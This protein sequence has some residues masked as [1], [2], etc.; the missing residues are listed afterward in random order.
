ML[1]TEKEINSILNFWF[2]ND[3]YNNFWFDK[4]VDE[5]IYKEYYHLLFNTYN[6]IVDRDDL[7][8]SY[9]ENL[10]L[11]ILFDQ[12][13]RNINR[14]VNINVSEMTY[15]ARKLSLI[16][17]KNKYYLNKKM[18]HICFMLMPLRHLNK[19]TDYYLILEILREI[20]EPNNFIFNKFKNQTMKKLDLLKD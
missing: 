6:T 9:E 4:S 3:D 7:E 2:P 17:I 19:L 11:I 12:F 14:I 8:F 13:S 15:E 16:S 20:E 1:L 18:N 5:K 10:A